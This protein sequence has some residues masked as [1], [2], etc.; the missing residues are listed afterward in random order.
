M[1]KPRGTYKV[2]WN[3][4][5]TTFKKVN[6]EL[7]NLIDKVPNKDNAPFYLAVF[8]WGEKIGD[9]TSQFIPQE[10]DHF[11]RLNSDNLPLDI[12]KN[13]GYAKSTTPVGMIFENTFE[14]YVDL[15]EKKL[16]L[17]AKLYTPGDFFGYTQLIEIKD[18]INYSPMGILSGMAGARSTFMLPP[19]SYKKKLD[20]LCGALGIRHKQPTTL[21]EH[22]QLFK[23]ILNSPQLT[24][25]W[26]AAILYFSNEWVKNIKENPIWV[27]IK[28]YFYRY[29]SK[30]TSY[31]LNLP[32]YNT[33]YSLC[34]AQSNQKPNPY[35]LDTF[36]H[37]MDIA[38]GETPGF[39]PQASDNLLPLRTLQKAFVDYYGLTYMPTIIA[40]NYFSPLSNTPSACYYSM[41][42]AATLL[43][44]PSST[45][46]SNITGI[47]E[48]IDIFEDIKKILSQDNRLCSNT[49]IQY[50]FKELEINFFHSSKNLS[51]GVKEIS[52]LTLADNAFVTEQY[53][54]LPHNID[55][56]FFKGCIQIR[57][58]QLL[59]K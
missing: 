6:P 9:E 21:Y 22:H 53:S 39:T 46:F 29:K 42:Y 54:H 50:I 4:I 33:A 14:W 43:F 38:A 41:S 35:L 13:L 51:Q 30:Q 11:L 3:D 7:F 2:F 40:P 56:P 36:K 28:N 17:P 18:K 24:T 23:A 49:I 27:E 58:P 1:T 55:S 25:N 52:N 47:R 34:L 16:T 44:S 32:F 19:I 20:K 26:H 57:K 5:K 10:K 37:I 15:A 45:K 8:N 31:R 59:E 48:L 12:Q